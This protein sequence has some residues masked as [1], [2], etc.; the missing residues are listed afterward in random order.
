MGAIAERQITMK[1]Y[2]VWAIYG[3]NTYS[4]YHLF[5]SKKEANKAAKYLR[6][7][8]L[9]NGQKSTLGRGLKYKVELVDL[10][11]P[12][13]M[14]A[15]ANN[16]YKYTMVVD[17]YFDDESGEHQAKIN[18]IQKKAVGMHSMAYGYENINEEC[19][20]AR[21]NK[22]H[23][24]TVLASNVNEA[25][26]RAIQLALPSMNIQVKEKSDQSS[27]NEECKNEL[28]PIISES[29]NNGIADQEIQSCDV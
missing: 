26:A 23:V 27:D 8:H 29:E 25:K 3:Y 20:Y 16:K 10:N 11:N 7:Q 15:I 12:D 28:I 9:E 2:A 18:A 14:F 4:L 21:N 17:I 6:Q 22:A 24:V 1:I 19:Y 5:T 13:I